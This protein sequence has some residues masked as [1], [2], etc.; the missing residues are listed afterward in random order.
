[1]TFEIR[2]WLLNC[3]WADIRFGSKADIGQRCLILSSGALDLV[4]FDEGK[5]RLTKV[6][7]STSKR[8]NCSFSMRTAIFS[9]REEFMRRLSDIV[10]YQNPLIMEQMTTVKAACH[11]MRERRAESVLVTDAKGSLVGIFTGR[12]AVCNVLA[13]GKVCRRPLL[14]RS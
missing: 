8:T 9:P 12:D 6:N 5:R 3:G 7:D 1:M 4:A 11:Q 10:C 14:V 13:A 2:V